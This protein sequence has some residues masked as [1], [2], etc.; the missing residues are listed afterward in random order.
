MG[1]PDFSKDEKIGPAIRRSS[2]AAISIARFA[3][4]R[5]KI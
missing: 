1:N 2:L 3:S 4:P 5:D